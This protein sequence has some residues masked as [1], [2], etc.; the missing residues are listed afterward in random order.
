MTQTS[1]SATAPTALPYLDGDVPLGTIPSADLLPV[2]NPANRDEVV[3]T[4]AL[5]SADHVD[6]ALDLAV[7]AAPGW[8]ALTATARADLLRS[9]ADALD[10]HDPAARAVL[11]TREHGK[12]RWES[13]LDVG[14]AAAILRYYA[15]LAAEFDAEVDHRNAAGTARFR[16]RPLGVTA[17]IVPW[18]YPVYLASLMLVPALLAGNPV[19]VKPSEVTP[20]ALTET[21]RI[22]AA[23]LP[24]GVVTVVPG[25]GSV[26]GTALTT[27]R[28]VR[29]VLFT[30][31]TATGRTIMAA[32]A[33]TLKRLGLELG[34]ND[35]A[36]V[37]ESAMIDDRLIDELVRGT[38]TSSGQVCY[39]VKRIYV[40]RSRYAE[41]VTAYTEAADA[42]VVGDGRDPETTIGPLTTRSQYD[43]VRAL[44]AEA[45]RHGARV[46]TVGRRGTTAHWERGNFLLPTVVTDAPHD[47][48]LVTE[49]QFGPTVP[50]LPFDTDDEAVALANGTDYGLAASVWSA[51]ASHADTVARRIEAGSVFVNAHRLGASDLA[52]P[53]GGAKQSG[54]G[55]RHGF[56]AVE[57]CS[58]LQ[59]IAHVVNP[60]SL[61]G[62]TVAA[63]PTRPSPSGR[64]EQ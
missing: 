40:H 64:K 38:F 39:S 17:V 58:E 44:V 46:R 49:E 62:P 26:A 53:F 3:G 43:R 9:A 14:G 45:R 1:T 30:G 2:R 61:P 48:A 11:L 56:V 41:L 60:A 6:R 33:P 15:G 18:N 7:A 25:T 8:A 20:L 59:T 42:L 57:E 50:I 32:A 19:V 22:L 12:V 29:A 55:R 24:P 21:L 28:R 34:G 16:R 27:D 5:G 51:D 36:L 10:R 13:T 63:P 4:V 52:M 35:P 31:S 54:L 23:A 47:I 37:L